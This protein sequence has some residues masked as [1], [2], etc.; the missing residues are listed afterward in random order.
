MARSAGVSLALLAD[1]RGRAPGARRAS[2]GRSWAPMAR[3]SPLGA[4]LE[5]AAAVARG[6]PR[7]STWPR[8]APSELGAMSKMLRPWRCSA[9]GSRA[10]PSPMARS[11]PR[12][13]PAACIRT[14]ATSGT[15]ALFAFSSSH[16]CPSH[17]IS[18]DP[19]AHRMQQRLPEISLLRMAWS[20]R[21]HRS[22]APRVSGRPCPRAR[23]GPCSGK[24]CAG[25]QP[26]PVMRLIASRWARSAAAFSFAA[27]RCSNRASPLRSGAGSMR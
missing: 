16:T 5:D 19:K 24:R 6:S 8:A 18:C 7:C 21:Y 4:V 1:D 13:S 9:A 27:S 15:L 23:P 10:A 11:S 25:R 17:P 14:H 20:E 2:S 12:C 22:T 26:R 3:C